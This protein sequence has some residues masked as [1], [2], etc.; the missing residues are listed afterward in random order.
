VSIDETEVAEPAAP[1]GPVAGAERA[2]AAQ[3][4]RARVW[5][6]LE[7]DGKRVGV[8]AL[9]ISLTALY[10]VVQN[11]RLTIAANRPELASNGFKIDL[12]PRPPH[13]EVDLENIGRMGRR[14]LAKLFSL[15]E[16]DGSPTEIGTAPIIGAGT[17]IF[18]GYGSAARFDSSS[19]GAAPFFLVCATYFDDSG[20]T[21][22]QAF[23]FERSTLTAR[24]PLNWLTQKWQ[25]PIPA[26]AG[27]KAPSRTRPPRFIFSKKSISHSRSIEIPEP[28]SFQK[29]HDS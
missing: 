24:T 27:T 11:Y 13:I 25:L 20:A 21:Y 14:G 7:V 23:L 28:S 8:P 10:F 12:T 29:W 3:T 9:I 18:P 4:K 6:W 22:R 15:T 5:D 1:P 26:D 19:I 16:A 2:I 17:N